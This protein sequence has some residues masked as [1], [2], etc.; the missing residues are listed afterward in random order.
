MISLL[1]LQALLMGADAAPAPTSLVPADSTVIILLGTGTPVPDPR[2]QGPAT[3]VVVGDRVFLFDAGPGVMRQIRAAGLPMR[4]VHALFLTHLH[5]DHTLG[6]PDL[7]LTSWV[8]RRQR[9]FPVF[10]PPGTRAMTVAL[11]SAFKEDIVMR[12]QGLEREVEGGYDVDIHE[13]GPGIVY[14]SGGVRITA[15]AVEHGDWRHAFGYRV[16]TPDR[17]IVIA[18]DTRPSAN[19]LAAARGVDVLIHEVYP[20][21]RVAP[22]ERPGGHLWPQY[23]KEFHTSDVELGE[24]AAEAAPAL[25]LLTHVVWLGGTEGEV[26]AGIR[27]GGYKGPVVFGRDLERY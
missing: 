27:Q 7:M 18:G 13:I 1:M 11:Q 20:H 8:M 10:G 16:D 14:D 15:F 5:S 19:V 12:T 6:Y 21:V 2:R 17:S 4:G 25:L 3:A 22:E 24:L 9:P 26:L 23:L